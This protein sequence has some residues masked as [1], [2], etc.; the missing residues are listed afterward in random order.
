MR[1]VDSLARNL[2]VEVV[3]EEFERT[4]DIAPAFAR[5]AR[6]VDA[7]YVVA[8]SL[9]YV[10]RATTSDL[11]LAARLPTVY[12]VREYVDVGGLAAVPRENPFR[13]LA[14]SLAARA[15]RMRSDSR[16]SASIEGE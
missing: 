1:D 8:E 3:A 13:L 2:D 11:A 5:F 9:A 12:S 16:Q 15:P 10:N 6:H 14:T 4:A 7:L